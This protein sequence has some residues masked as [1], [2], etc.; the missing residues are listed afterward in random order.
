MKN[1]KIP[2]RKCLGCSEKKEKKDLI[3]IVKAPS[4]T[5]SDAAGRPEISLDLTGKLPGRGAYICKNIDCLNKS[6]KSRRLEKTFKCKIPDDIYE[7]LE[8]EL[9][10]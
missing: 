8:R 2:L 6:K 4:N 3:K 10:S 9:N 5:L 7:A 1:K